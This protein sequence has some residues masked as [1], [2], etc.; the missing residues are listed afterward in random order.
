MLHSVGWGITRLE[1][2]GKWRRGIEGVEGDAVIED[3]GTW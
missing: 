1:I 3:V 2:E